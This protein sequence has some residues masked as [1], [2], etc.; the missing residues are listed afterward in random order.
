MHNC[1]TL[2]DKEK[3]FSQSASVPERNHTAGVYISY[4]K[5]QINRVE[6]PAFL[7]TRDL[8]LPLL[9]ARSALYS[10]NRFAR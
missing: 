6:E 9:C 4:I 1:T 10:T 3:K 5:Q 7:P 2:L 8:K